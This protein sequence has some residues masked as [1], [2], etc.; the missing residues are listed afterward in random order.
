M[1]IQSFIPFMYN[2]IYCESLNHILKPREFRSYIPSQS[3]SRSSGEM[4]LAETVLPCAFTAVL[5]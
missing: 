2:I 5:H 1:K 4:Q 3:S